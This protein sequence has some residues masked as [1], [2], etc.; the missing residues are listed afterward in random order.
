MSNSA[1]VDI[2]PKS[3]YLQTLE[4]EALESLFQEKVRAL[5]SPNQDRSLFDAIS[6]E[7]SRRWKLQELKDMNLRHAKQLRS[8]ADEIEKRAS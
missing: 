2:S 7:L 1:G 6:T 5:Q 4:T 8:L 3:L